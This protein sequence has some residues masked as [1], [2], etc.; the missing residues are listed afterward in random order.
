MTKQKEVLTKILENT[1]NQYD[2]NYTSFPEDLK[3]VCTEKEFN[4]VKNKYYVTEI[5]TN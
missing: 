4:K 2:W 3:L 1:F 5:I